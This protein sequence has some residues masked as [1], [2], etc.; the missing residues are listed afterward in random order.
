MRAVKSLMAWIALKVVAVVVVSR[1]RSRV[2]ARQAGRS[3]A[4]TARPGPQQ[5][6]VRKQGQYQQGNRPAQ[7]PSR[8]TATKGLVTT[9]TSTTSGRSPIRWSKPDRRFAKGSKRITSG[10]GR[11]DQ[12]HG[13]GGGDRGNKRPPSA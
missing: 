2:V 1:S 9:M 3:T 12:D 10:F 4:A 5:V 11:P 6:E 7:R 8:L 13:Q